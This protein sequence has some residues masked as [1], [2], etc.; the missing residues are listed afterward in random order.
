L[1]SSYNNEI[2]IWNANDFS[3]VKTFFE[4]GIENSGLAFSK[5]SKILLA[6]N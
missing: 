3:L 6:I 2:K 4:E 1:A 5:D